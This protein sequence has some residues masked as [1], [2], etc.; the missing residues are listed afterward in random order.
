MLNALLGEELLPVSHSATTA[1]IC[2]L[3]CSRDDGKK[4]AVIHF[5]Q[6]SE[7]LDLEDEQDQEKFRRYVNKKNHRRSTNYKLEE[8]AE[9]AA[10]ADPENS[11]SC[12]RIEIF[13]PLEFLKV[14]TNRISFAL[15][16]TLLQDV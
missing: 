10:T 14:R 1:V 2:E 9:A 15:P 11:P 5:D 7:E 4:M 8:A 3:K 12:N 16:N 13:W 6:G